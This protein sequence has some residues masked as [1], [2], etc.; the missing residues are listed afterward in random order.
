MSVIFPLVVV[1]LLIASGFLALFVWAVRTGQFDDTCTPSMRILIE[2]ERA[3]GKTNKV[4]PT[5]E[6][7]EEHGSRNL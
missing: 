4:N 1:S 6:K 7:D 3:T 5:G 2:D